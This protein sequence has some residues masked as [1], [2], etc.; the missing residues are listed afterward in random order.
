MPEAVKLSVGLPV[1]NGEKYL[2]QALESLLDQSFSD[3][4]LIV[5]DNASTDRTP[6]IARLFAS[7]DER[8]RYTR[9]ETNLGAAANFNRVFQLSSGRYFKWAAYDDVCGRDFLLRCVESL[10]GDSRLILAYPRIVWIDEGGNQVQPVRSRLSVTSPMPSARFGNVMSVL[11]WCLPIFGAIRREALEMTSL[12][13]SVGSDHVLLAELSLHG[14]FHE[15]PEALF[16][17][18]HHRERYVNSHQTVRQKADWWDPAW[19]RTLRMPKWHQLSR[20][21]AAI[22]RAPLSTRERLA[23]YVHVG[24]WVMRSAG[25]LMEDV[26]SL[27]SVPAHR[28][29]E[30]DKSTRSIA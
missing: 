18:R 15:I 7:R 27:G 8:V 5:S 29:H 6:A 3:F 19:R 12:M 25:S 26:R 11:N 2:E 24:H 20:Y 10:D 30:P 17:H 16:F 9:S 1:R 4:E 14:R 22:G 23:C 21:I 13:T 28:S